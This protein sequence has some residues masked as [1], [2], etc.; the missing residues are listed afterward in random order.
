M[1]RSDRPDDA[2]RPSS[3]SPT[4]L[5][6]LE[7]SPEALET[8]TYTSPAQARLHHRH[9]SER[10]RLITAL[11]GAEDEQTR[12]RAVRL[13]GCCQNPTF[14]AAEDREGNELLQ[15]RLFCCRDRLCPFCQRARGLLCSTR[16]AAA[17]KRANSARFLTLTQS[18]R[19][20][21]P[22]RVALD[23]LNDSFRTIRL[24]DEWKEK[25]RGGVWTIEVT[26]NTARG[27]WHCHLHLIADGSF[28]K[29]AELSALWTVVTGDSKIV[30]IRAVHDH[31]V[32]A[33][34]IASYVAKPVNLE[35]WSDAEICEY[36][37]AMH[38]RRLLSTFGSMH[39]EKVD[40]RPTDKLRP[41]SHRLVSAAELHEAAAAGNERASNALHLIKQTSSLW[42]AATG[43]TPE[44][45]ELP[46]PPAEHRLIELL[47]AV[48]QDW[49]LRHGQPPPPEP[50]KPREKE[51]QGYFRGGTIVV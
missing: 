42:A 36:A 8:W 16:I 43:Q 11:K 32:T 34:Y 13:A 39:G 10:T 15:L 4:S 20:G 7:T 22:L 26:R 12:K 44:N 41:H 27:S 25:V 48:R 33:V 2:S 49:S 18:D 37:A 28:W 45:Y 17:T 50:P 38:G 46:E 5:D 21:E 3:S 31:T 30:D 9:A 24:S 19:A 23:R 51:R 35:Q 29:Q 1:C 40:P 47:Y 14:F 6:P